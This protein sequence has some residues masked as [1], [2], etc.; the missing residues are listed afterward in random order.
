MGSQLNRPNLPDKR[1]SYKRPLLRLTLD[2]RGENKAHR[3][4]VR[5]VWP[6]NTPPSD[7]LGTQVPDARVG[8]DVPVFLLATIALLHQEDLCTVQQPRLFS[9]EESCYCASGPGARCATH[10]FR[11]VGHRLC[12]VCLDLA[13]RQNDGLSHQVR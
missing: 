9:E 11:V 12:L 1:D 6:R 5:I 7:I 10:R 13:D 2:T 4:D 8:A 3:I